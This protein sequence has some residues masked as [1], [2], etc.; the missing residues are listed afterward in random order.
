[1]D[2]IAY[3]GHHCAYC[4]FD[5]CPGCRSD[6]PFCS[7]ATLFADNICPNVRCCKEKGLDGCYE[8]KDLRECRIGFFDTQEQVA[9]ATAL[10]IQKYGKE[11]YTNSLER[12]I[13]SGVRYPH[14]F[15]EM[16][17]VEK[18]IELLKKYISVL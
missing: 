6:N 16:G 5:Q 15:N 18:M 9:K 13:Q 7:Y 11:T 3:C 1:M 2:K 8:C 12:A 4:H 17:D 10:F 14:Q